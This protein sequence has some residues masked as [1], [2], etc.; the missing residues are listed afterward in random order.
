METI[1]KNVKVKNAT[2]TTFDN[3]NFKSKLE[4][5]T[6][7]KLKENNLEPRYEPVKFVL[8][9]SFKYKNEKVRQ[10]TYKPDFVSY[11]YVIECKGW[12]NDAFPLRWKI[13][14]YYLF[15]N[16]LDY[17]IYLV[18]NHK[19]VNAAIEKILAKRKKNARL[20]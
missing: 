15:R 10:M 12:G 3:I 1:I 13:F 18:R 17:D 16:N 7:K 11:D 14:K 2:P 8:I 20:S 6:Y 4:V 19:D 5:Y 9:D